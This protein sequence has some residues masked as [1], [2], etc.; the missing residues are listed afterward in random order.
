MSERASSNNRP[1]KLYGAGFLIVLAASGTEGCTADDSNEFGP[2]VS[3]NTQW[4][5][6]D[7]RDAYDA[8][9]ESGSIDKN[10]FYDDTRILE[11]S[12]GS[13]RE[14]QSRVAQSLYPLHMEAYDDP[15]DYA[16]ASCIAADISGAFDPANILPLQELE[17]EYQDPT[18]ERRQ[19]RV[20]ADIETF[21]ADALVQ[22]IKGRGAEDVVSYVLPPDG[23]W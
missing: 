15:R 6:N 13:P 10:V 22:H 19:S 17:R 12:E 18:S 7:V 20:A 8:L 3:R 16:I 2:F 21:C 23:E 1:N 14:L 9:I 5:V 11:V 4:R